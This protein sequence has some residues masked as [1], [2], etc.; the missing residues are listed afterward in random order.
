MRLLVL[1]WQDRL[2]PFAGGAESHLHEV[3]GRLAARGHR[4]TLLVSGWKGAARRA[5]IDGMDVHRAGGRLTFLLAARRYFRSRLR[6]EA[7]DVVVEDL[8]KVPLF[9][10]YWMGAPLVLLVHHL[11]GRTAF[12]EAGLAMATATWALERPLGR[13]YRDVPVQA[14]SESTAADLVRRGFRRERIVVIPNGV[15]L[16]FFS[17][18][19]SMPAMSRTV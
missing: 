8:H 7:F 5:V 10:P 12:R 13:V 9:P 6:R 14:V 15:D 3:F 11:F 1:N 17:P 2:N 4:V 18:D 16:D 19:P